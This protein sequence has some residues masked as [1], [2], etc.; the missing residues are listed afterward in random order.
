MVAFQLC[1]SHT[2]NLPYP[3]VLLRCHQERSSG[4]L[5]RGH[6]PPPTHL[7]YPPPQR[8]E[9]LQQ[10]RGPE[11][12][13]CDHM[14][15]LHQHK[16]HKHPETSGKIYHIKKN[17][18]E[19]H[20]KERELPGAI[21]EGRLEAREAHPGG[22]GQGVG[23]CLEGCDLTPDRRTRPRGLESQR[24]RKLES[25]Q[26]PPCAVCSS[27]DSCVQW[28]TAKLRKAA[29]PMEPLRPP[30]NRGRKTS[31]GSKPSIKA[32]Q[33][34]R[35]EWCCLSRERAIKTGPGSARTPGRPLG[36]ELPEVEGG[37]SHHPTETENSSPSARVRE[38]QDGRGS[39]SQKKK[40]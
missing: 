9:A 2:Q 38:K 21:N 20:K 36:P 14:A 16:P 40:K 28:L 7:A 13:S 12:S 5:G 17:M 33:A 37:H 24:C 10:Q 34:A 3:S 39:T 8:P 30:W 19:A 15:G 23:R 11:G 27:Q 32:V 18:G 29:S 31:G 25:D 26:H 4:R 1:C 35:S 22:S 6:G